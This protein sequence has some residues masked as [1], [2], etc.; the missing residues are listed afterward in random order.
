MASITSYTKKS[1]ERAWLVKFR[2]KNDDNRQIKKMGFRTKAE[3]KAYAD[4][5]ENA[6]NHGTFV[7]PSKGKNVTVSTLAATWLENK[8]GTSKRKYYDTLVS[9]WHTHVEPAFG[10]RAVSSIM[11]SEIQTWV[12]A[13][14]TGDEKRGI[15]ARS[16]SVVQ[17][18][19]TILKG[20][21][22]MAVADKIIKTSPYVHIVTPKKRHKARVYL[23][24]EQL[25]ALADATSREDEH[26]IILTLGLCG[27]RYGEARALRA[28][29]ID[30][31]N[32]RFRITA[33]M[34]RLA[35]G[36]LEVTTPK[37]GKPRTVPVPPQL[38][39]ALRKHCERKQP[40]DLVFTN[41]YGAPIQECSRANPRTWYARALKKA[42]VRTVH[43]DGT[44]TMEPVPS[45][46]AHDLRHTAASL[47]VSDGANVKV[48]QRMLGHQ[49]A[50]MTLDT[51]A[52]LFDKDLDD[53]ANNMGATISRV[54]GG[55]E[56]D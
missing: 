21:L 9:T 22:D 40:D 15:P 44:V 8:R 26:L 11:P 36:E 19:A 53:L 24:A 7:H 34:T 35:S 27:L 16:A 25:F 5:A 52:D 18:A 30:Y 31:E 39:D 6:V 47:A 56:S 13:M 2:D 28:K 38:L 48:L 20:V 17:R 10:S 51:Y 55:G 23:T 29:D 50:A 54:R 4:E 37:T 12:S 43:E 3:A 41:K 33:S 45:L 46:T 1:G 49:S 42:R 32:G 14:S